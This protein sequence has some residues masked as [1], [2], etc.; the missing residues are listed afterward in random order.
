MR[1]LNIHK[2]HMIL[3][4]TS[5]EASEITAVDYVFR[6]TTFGRKLKIFICFITVDTW[7]ISGWTAS[8]CRHSKYFGWS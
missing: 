4:Q 1:F 7:W 6:D 8:S 3:S 2:Y 5:G